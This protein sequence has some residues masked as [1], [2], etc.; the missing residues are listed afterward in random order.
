MTPKKK[1]KKDKE[2]EAE[3]SPE[4]VSN[5]IIIGFIRFSKI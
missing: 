1:K 4:E 3:D 2:K 5:I